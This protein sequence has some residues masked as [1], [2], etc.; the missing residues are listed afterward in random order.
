M[1]ATI[2]PANFQIFSIF[3]RLKVMEASTHLNFSTAPQTKNGNNFFLPTSQKIDT[4]I[5]F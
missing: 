4:S 5:D 1:S 3:F 2:A